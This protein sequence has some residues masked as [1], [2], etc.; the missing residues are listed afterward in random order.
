M[1]EV[2]KEFAY[3]GEQE[4]RTTSSTCEDMSPLFSGLY[5]NTDSDSIA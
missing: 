3:A 2:Q 5:P 1:K 4:F